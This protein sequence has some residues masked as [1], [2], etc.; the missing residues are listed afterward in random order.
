[1]DL[2]G[3]NFGP[4]NVIRQ[5]GRGGMGEVYEVEH[6]VLRKRY[7][8]KLLR[9]DFS[10]KSESVRRFELEAEVMAKLE[11]PHI[12]RVDGFGI[13][14]GRRTGNHYVG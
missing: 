7:A 4:Y 5:L 11:H 14:P 6:R 1:M 3:K 8:L 10:Q 12:V 13:S 2:S 9:E